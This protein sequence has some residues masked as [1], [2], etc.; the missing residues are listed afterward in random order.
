MFL[1]IRV[2]GPCYKLQGKNE[3]S[4]FTLRSKKTRLVICLLYDLLFEGQ[5]KQ[6]QV[7]RFERQAS[8]KMILLANENN[9]TTERFST[10]NS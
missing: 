8:Q 1:T 3:D 5:V 4:Q 6:V 9:G 10:S 7:K 2:L